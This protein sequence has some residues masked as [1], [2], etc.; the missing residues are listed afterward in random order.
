MSNGSLSGLVAICAC[1][2]EVEFK[3]A[4]LIGI[5]AGAVYELG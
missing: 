2:E 5:I 4:L 3:N 1:A